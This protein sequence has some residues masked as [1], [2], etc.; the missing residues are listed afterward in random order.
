MLLI[1]HSTPSHDPWPQKRAPASSHFAQEWIYFALVECQQGQYCLNGVCA[2]CPENTYKNTTGCGKCT[3]CPI[4]TVTGPTTGETGY[5]HSY[6]CYSMCYFFQISFISI[7]SLLRLVSSKV[8]NY[9]NWIA[10]KFK[11]SVCALDPT[12]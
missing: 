4:N 12:K 6:D 8:F 9:D 5:H 10:H 3:P 11:T 7:H 2:S 1:F